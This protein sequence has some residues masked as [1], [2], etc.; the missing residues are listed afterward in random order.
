M[1]RNKRSPLFLLVLV[2]GLTP[3]L[4]QAV[5]NQTGDSVGFRFTGRLQAATSC[6]ISND[7]VIVVDFGNV[8]VNRV[9]S[10]NYMREVS[11]TL[12]CGSAGSSNTISMVFKAT[13]VPSDPATFASSAPGLWVKVLKDGQPVEL[14]KAFTVAS[15]QTP[16]RIDVQLVKDPAQNLIEGTFSA[17]GT[18]MAE[19]V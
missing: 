16:P 15:P 12:D 5:S 13:P 4:S 7:Q 8:A 14:N 9:D 19:Y 10:G 3:V 11:Y 18:L 17:T 1:V 2:A 6:I